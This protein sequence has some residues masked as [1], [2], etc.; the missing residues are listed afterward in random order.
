MK[1]LLVGLL[2][3]TTFSAF[4]SSTCLGRYQQVAA[5]KNAHKQEMVDWT[6]KNADFVAPLTAGSAVATVI[7][8]VALPAAVMFG[9]YQSIMYGIGAAYEVSNAIGSKEERALDYQNKAEKV[10][11]FMKQTLKLAQKKNSSITMEEIVDI[12]DRGFESEDFCSGKKLF[13]PKQ[14]R[15]YVLENL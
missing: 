13:G 8:P 3:L 7:N 1:K 2:T 15:K 11:G 10:S 9:G 6:K 14:I 5:K 4:A 12:I